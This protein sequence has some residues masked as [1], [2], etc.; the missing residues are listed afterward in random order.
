MLIDPMPID[1]LRTRYEKTPRTIDSF[2]RPLSQVETG[3]RRPFPWGLMT[4][5]VVALT[6]L[7]FGIAEVTGGAWQMITMLMLP[8]QMGVGI[9]IARSASPNAR[10][11]KLL[12][13]ATLVEGRVVKAH[14][15]LYQPSDEPEEAIVVFSTK[16]AARFDRT[17]LR[18]V[19]RVVRSAAEADT[20]PEGMAEVVKVVNGEGWPAKVPGHDGAWVARV[21]VHPRRLP[22]EKIVDQ[23]LPLL[24]A[25]ADNLVAHI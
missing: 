2:L 23:A 6:A 11:A 12:R 19:G 15:R 13:T 8:V 20:P 21:M 4:F 1:E 25:P 16:D 14:G 17:A 9:Q 24:V 7:A 3:D 10:T 18:D 22:E 5:M